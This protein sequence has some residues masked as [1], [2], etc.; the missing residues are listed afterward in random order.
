MAEL[1]AVHERESFKYLENKEYFE[2]LL[3]VY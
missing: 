3:F 2:G 1:L